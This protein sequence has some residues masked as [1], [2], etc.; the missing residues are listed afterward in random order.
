[1]QTTK[2]PNQLEPTIN[3]A[4]LDDSDSILVPKS[5]Q[6]LNHAPFPQNQAVFRLLFTRRA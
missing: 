6:R 4:T 1:M 3:A 2:L 5:Q